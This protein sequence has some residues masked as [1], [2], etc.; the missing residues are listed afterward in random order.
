MPTEFS[1]QRFAE[2]MIVTM[3]LRKENMRKMIPECFQLPKIEK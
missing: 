1:L 3:M 2:S